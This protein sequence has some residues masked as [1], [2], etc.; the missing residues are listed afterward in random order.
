MYDFQVYGAESKEIKLKEAIVK[1]EKTR[2]KRIGVEIG[3]SEIGSHSKAK[4]LGL[5]K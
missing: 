3:K 4:E 1:D 5:S 2:W